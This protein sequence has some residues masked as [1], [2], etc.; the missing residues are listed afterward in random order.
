MRGSGLNSW[1]LAVDFCVHDGEFSVSR[2]GWKFL[3]QLDDSLLFLKDSVTIGR[4]L[5]QEGSYYLTLAVS[6]S[7]TGQNEDVPDSN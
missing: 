2:K 5:C 1:S 6:V 4:C 7:D 3:V